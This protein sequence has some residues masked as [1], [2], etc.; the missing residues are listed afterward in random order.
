MSG[1]SPSSNNLTKALLPTPQEPQHFQDS[2]LSKAF[3]QP[4]M[5]GLFLPLQTGGWSQSTLPRGTDWS[6]EYNTQLTQ[7]AEN[8][9][10]DIAFGLSQWLPKGGFGGET[11]YRENFLDPFISAV[12]LASVTKRILL[13]GTIHVLYGPWHP[14][15]LAKFLATADHI[16]NGRFGAN[17]VTGYAENE[18]SM[19]GMT[20]AEHDRRYAQSAEFTQIC[21]A[22]WAGEDNLTYNGGFYSL[23]NAYV[24]P[25][26]RYGRP[27]LAT[28]SGSPAGFDYA[29]RYSDIVFVSSPAG[30]K[31]ADALP[32]LPAHVAK[33]KDAAAA[34]GR[35]VRVI[36]N[37]TII[38]R[39]TREEAFA[40]YQSIMDHADLGA[41]RNFTDRHSAGDS[42]SW[43]EHSA[44]GRAV[45]G[46]L[47]IIGSPEEVAEQLQQL[48]AAGI[49]GIQITFYDYEP[50]L[51]Y[52][53]EAVIPLL[54]Q[55]G[56]RL[57][58]SP[59]V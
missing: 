3:A 52:F 29:S 51:A 47:H 30:E 11:H 28:A 55:A 22:L 33:V 12:A 9:G 37:P 15:H 54:E 8:L 49:D 58:V 31:L 43:L 40:Y 27:V 18:P 1:T 5:L 53:G 39:P 4:L 13:M 48:H 41:I 20:R 10:F 59:M 21:N 36:I 38:V 45:G 19:F 23:E 16:S 44:R 57:P 24:S 2:P 46:H 42:Q 25:R 26:P 35:Q 56:L 50:E 32:K 6:F 7:Q 14:M 17:I 34:R